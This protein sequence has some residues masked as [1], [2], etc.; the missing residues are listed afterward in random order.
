MVEFLKINM[1]LLDF[2]SIYSMVHM[3][4]GNEHV[5]GSWSPLLS[6]VPQVQFFSWVWQYQ[7]QQLKLKAMYK[8]YARTILKWC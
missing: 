2:D 1:G 6:L 4:T 5:E 7:L 3:R 8:F